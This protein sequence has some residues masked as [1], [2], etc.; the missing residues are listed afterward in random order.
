M[1]Q[2]AEPHVV[3]KETL[4]SES[5]SSE[6]P[7][8]TVGKLSCLTEVFLPCL[9]LYAACE[10]SYGNTLAHLV[11]ILL[12]AIGV[13]SVHKMS[14]KFHRLPCSIILFSLIYSLAY[15]ITET[16]IYYLPKNKRPTITKAMKCF[17]FFDNVDKIM[18]KTTFVI[19][20]MII[21]FV[22]FIYL[23][24]RTTFGLAWYSQARIVIMRH[25]M[26][27][28][29]PLFL[30]TQSVLVASTNSI[31]LTFMPVIFALKI[32]SFCLLSCN[33]PKFVSHI[34]WTLYVI[35]DIGFIAYK[36]QSFHGTATY[37]WVPRWAVVSAAGVNLLLIGA[38][39]GCNRYT[40]SFPIRLLKN[41]KVPGWFLHIIPYIVIVTSGLFCILEDSWQSYGVL[42]FASFTSLFGVDF[43]QR[44]S[45]FVLT[46][47]AGVYCGQ[48]LYFYIKK[49]P[50]FHPKYNFII[51]V[52]QAISAVF[53]HCTSSKKVNLD[54]ESPEP[55]HKWMNKIIQSVIVTI[56]LGNVIL[57]AIFSS[58]FNFLTYDIPLAFILLLMIFKLFYRWAWTILNLITFASTSIYFIAPLL[59]KPLNIPWLFDGSVTTEPRNMLSKVWPF[60]ILFLLTAIQRYYYR[61]PP[62][63]VIKFSKT[64][65]VFLALCLSC[66][67]IDNSI[68]TVLYQLL[69][70]ANLFLYKWNYVLMVIN[71]ILTSLQIVVLAAFGY[72]EIKNKFTNSGFY[73]KFFGIQTKPDVIK[74]QMSPIIILIMYTFFGSIARKYDTTEDGKIPKWITLIIDN[75]WAIILKFSFY[76]FWSAIFLMVIVSKGVSIVGAVMLMVLGIVKVL[77]C[78]TKQIGVVLYA[79]FIIDVLFVTTVAIVNAPEKVTKVVNLIGPLCDTVLAKFAN[80]LVCLC[81]FI[82]MSH[83]DTK[84]IHPIITNIGDCLA[85]ILISG[86]EFTLVVMAIQ[87]NN[88]LNIFGVVLVLIILL[89]PRM[90]LRGARIITIILN[91][92]LG[93]VLALLIVKFNKH[94]TWYDYLLL[95]NI[96]MIEVFYIFLTMF[97]FSLFCE[98]GT[99]NVS[100]GR[101]FLTAY[102]P[103]I[104]SVAATVISF[105][106][107]TYLTMVHTIMLCVNLLFSF[108][109]NDFHLRSFTVVIWYAFAIILIKSLRPLRFIPQTNSVF[110]Q[111][112]GTMKA[113]NL[114]W[115]VC[116]W[117][118][119]L[120]K[121]C[122]DS[123]LYNEVHAKELKR[124]EFRRNR[125]HIIEEMFEIDHKYCDQ[126]FK[127]TLEVLKSGIVNLNYTD[128]MDVDADL[129]K[130]SSSRDPIEENKEQQKKEEEK[131]N[132]GEENP[133][134]PDGN[135]DQPPMSAT[136]QFY[137]TILKF[138]LMCLKTAFLWV[139]DKLIVLVSNFTDINLEPGVHTQFLER[140]RDMMNEMVE[141]F[142]NT[143]VL[144]IPQAYSGFVQQIP[145]S[146]LYHFQIFHKLQIKTI[147]EKNRFP[148]FYH[149]V[150]LCSRQFIP[151]LLLAMCFYYP[152]EERSIFALFM[153]FLALI[154]V[155]FNVETYIPFVITSGI[156][157]FMRCLLRSYA[158][159]PLVETFIGSLEENHRKLRVSVCFGLDL[160]VGEKA[161]LLIVFCLACASQTYAFTHPFQSRRPNQHKVVDPE[162]A[163]PKLTFGEKLLRRINMKSFIQYSF[164]KVVLLIDVIAFCIALFFYLSW[165]VSSDAISF[166]SGSATITYDFVFFL[167]GNFI[168]VLLNQWVILSKHKLWLFTFNF[169]YGIFTFIYM[170]YLIPVFTD[171]SCFEHSTFWI[172]Y[173]LRILSEIIYSCNIMF[174]FAR[175]PPSLGNPNALF[176]YIKL[177]TITKTPF[178][179]EF[180]QLTKWLACTTS[181]NMFDFMI[182]GQLRSKLSKQVALLKL[183]PANSKKKRHTLGIFFVIGLFC[184]LFVPFVVMM[185]SS[186]TSIPNGVKVA[187]VSLGIY[188]LPELFTGTVLPD[189]TTLM[190]DSMQKHVMTMN[191][192][193]LEPFFANSRKESQYF[194]Y[195]SITMTNWIISESSARFAMNTIKNTSNPIFIPYVTFKFT[196]QTPTTKKNVDQITI[197]KNG[198]QLKPEVLETLYKALECTMNLATPENLSFYLD[199]LV[200]LF[201]IIP[202]AKDASVVSNYY[203]N[204]TFTFE[205]ST[206]GNFY[207][208]ISTKRTAKQPVDVQEGPIGSVVFSK[209]TYDAVISTLMSKTGGGFYGL[210]VFFTLSCGK[211][212]RS[213]INSFFTD[214]WID[215]MGKPEI[216]LNVILAIE[217][218]R[219]AG[220]LKSEYATAMMLLNTIR[221]VHNLVKIG[222]TLPIDQEEAIK[223][224]GATFI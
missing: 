68:F 114:Q 124:A 96:K 144:T 95:T 116:F 188:G 25:V 142:V 138:V 209:P 198:K 196:V 149:Y 89:H 121:C 190:T 158:L 61:P 70:V 63:I 41:V 69:I 195:P 167:M 87:E 39:I 122:L 145:M 126:N 40:H 32:I 101:S 125:A 172:F 18:F 147:D 175:M 3:Q 57:N 137:M 84:E 97:A 214:L 208:S 168:F 154:C 189:D 77:G 93:Y 100:V 49:Q 117:L 156:Y 128:G 30:F 16:T 21:I 24:S 169:L 51:C 62:K 72:D 107:H 201:F 6:E 166:F 120:L 85:S 64:V 164:N 82:N 59:K 161:Y 37:A 177:L 181:L 213:F 185:S 83:F 183:F 222:G 184:L 197:T 202:L 90:S 217:A 136:K 104:L 224:R 12:Y 119:F 211:M 27:L 207:W 98:F 151:A 55:E 131:P 103:M 205:Q 9:W 111:A 10:G 179:F 11:F 2:P 23:A 165:T 159:D 115:C 65:G 7:K 171:N 67:Y 219:K 79:I 218:H 46:A 170:T 182:I 127:H 162:V 143:N 74:D 13:N 86:V 212:V 216:F 20:Q 94:N 56:F 60:L 5:T 153:F 4:V 215:K 204:T 203:F 47:M 1:E 22:D 45:R 140:L 50:G 92:V 191:D 193:T 210:Y 81:A 163:Q 113:D 109:T 38:I 15:F 71:T 186:S 48:T 135:P 141:T 102:F 91:F 155:A 52:L 160:N 75:C 180:I 123:P 200:P 206:N 73:F 129:I 110:D 112:M 105:Y 80:V 146:Y 118:E 223:G 36:D 194:T 148:L 178:L 221:S 108:Y 53:V 132:E 76:F 28:I 192:K 31:Y 187:T 133:V 29:R 134:G 26:I 174:G 176:T 88:I 78:R 106:A 152:M 150:K 14:T 173:F 54:N 43:L 130:F 157:M 8:F 42:A 220:D 44:S 34:Y 35:G 58:K 66:I 17:D 99:L 139:I 33:M 19:L 199:D